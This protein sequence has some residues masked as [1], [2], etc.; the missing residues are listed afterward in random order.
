MKY[1]P[2]TKELFTDNGTFL[3]KL[4]CPLAKQWEELIE[5][6]SLKG[7]MCNQCQKTVFDTALLS[8]IELQNIITGQPHA[9]VK[10]DINQDNLTITY[11][12]NGK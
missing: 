1:N 4:H 11:Q 5:T 9:C 3:K 6:N 7:K 10:V 2:I 12:Q 8:D